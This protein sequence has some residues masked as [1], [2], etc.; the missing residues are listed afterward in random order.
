MKMQLVTSIAE[1][2]TTLS[3]QEKDL[4]FVFNKNGTITML[5]AEKID[6]LK[7]L[8]YKCNSI[9]RIDILSINKE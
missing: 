2:N 4:I 8:L 9:K 5:F 1:A 3:P 6:L 7:L